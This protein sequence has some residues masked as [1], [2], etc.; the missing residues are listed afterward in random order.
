M[1]KLTKF[2]TA[3]TVSEASELLSKL[4]DEPISIDDIEALFRSNRIGMIF[5]V[6][7]NVMILTDEFKSPDAITHARSFEEPTI[8][9]ATCKAIHLPS[10]EIYIRSAGQ[11]AIHKAIA[12]RDT[13]GNFYALNITQTDEPDSFLPKF[14]GRIHNHFPIVKDGFIEPA[15]IYRIAAEANQDQIPTLSSLAIKRNNWCIGKADLYN[16]KPNITTNEACI[17]NINSNPASSFSHMT[18]ELKAMQLAANHFWVTYEK[19]RPPLQK[20]VSNFIAEKLGLTGPNRKT[21]ALAAA[22]RPTDAPDSQR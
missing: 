10:E 11:K 13:V 7:A 6:T 5:Q 16:F 1:S 3:L 15:E 17:E 12:L 14:L 4:I 9:V 20:S 22:I 8:S 21:D 2:K 18:F 19:E